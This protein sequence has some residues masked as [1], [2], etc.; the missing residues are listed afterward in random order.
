M[1]QTLII[2]FAFI[3]LFSFSQE[4]PAKEYFPLVEKGSEL[5]SKK[6]YKGSVEAYEKAF[7]LN[8]GKALHED[9][10]NAACS[11][12]LVGNIDTTFYH[13]NR[14]VR[15]GKFANYRRIISDTDLNILHKDKR[16]LSL[17]DTILHNKEIAEAKLNKPL[18]KIL[19]TILDEDQ[20]YRLQFDEIEKNTIL[21]NET[22]AKLRDEAGQKSMIADGKNLKKVIAILDKYGWL[23]PEEIGE[24]GNSTLFL[25]IQHSYQ[26]IQEKYLPMMREAVK[27]K[28]AHAWDLALLEDRV[29]LGQGKKQIYGSQ[30]TG[31]GKGSYKLSPVED[32]ANLNKR[33]AEVGLQPIEE[34]LKHWNIVYK[35]DPNKIEEDPIRFTSNQV[36]L[37]LALAYILIF[38]VLFWFMRTKLFLSAWF[39][40]FT[41]L[42]AIN[43][44]G[45]ITDIKNG[46]PYEPAKWLLFGSTGVIVTI[47]LSLLLNYILSIVCKRKHLL[48][49][50]ISIGTITFLSMYCWNAFIYKLFYSEGGMHFTLNIFNI[51]IPIGIY[52]IIK[53]FIWLVL[54]IKRKGQNV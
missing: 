43:S 13:L 14:L 15:K 34:Y 51:L 35:Y 28:K 27:N 49:E 53:T 31:D 2:L 19:D 30:L 5:Y 46:L 3:G 25:V 37:F 32:E 54:R 12:A 6:D 36:I 18:V 20:K 21:S 33:R 7:K 9:R 11:W 17:L 42:F 1:K 50:V 26:D 45:Q 47:T 23:G 44:L 52:L 38:L 4:G 10:Y 22:K 16:W 29:L 39:W 40:F 41:V 8:D 24:E 48:I